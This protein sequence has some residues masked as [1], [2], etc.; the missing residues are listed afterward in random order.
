MAPQYLRVEAV[1][2]P[3]LTGLVLQLWARFLF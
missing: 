1:L 3:R 2:S